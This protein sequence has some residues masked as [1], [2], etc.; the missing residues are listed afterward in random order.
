M[1]RVVL[2]VHLRRMTNTGREVTLDIEGEATFSAVLDTLETQYPMLRGTIRDYVSKERRAYIRY[3]ACGE[4]YSHHSA[5]TP[6]PEA[7]KNG[8]ETLRIV[9]AM[10][11]G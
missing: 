10:S 8:T 2:P 7:V 3:F 5:D 4:D 9:G 11:G 6:L 1:I